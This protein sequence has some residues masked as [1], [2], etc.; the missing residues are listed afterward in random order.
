MIGNENCGAEILRLDIDSCRDA[1]FLEKPIKLK[2][3]RFEDFKAHL[4]E[5]TVLTVRKIRLLNVPVTKRMVSRRSQ[6]QHSVMVRERV[7]HF[8]GVGGGHSIEIHEATTNVTPQGTATEIHHDS[9]PHIST[10]CGESGTSC[11]QPM[12]LW[13]LWKASESRRLATCYSDTAAALR[14][15]GPCRYPIQYAGESLLL[16]ANVP[17]AALS[18]S[19]RYLYS[20]TFHA[21]GRARDP[22]TLELELSALAKRF[23]NNLIGM[24]SN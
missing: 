24:G 20:Q 11:E 12:K 17:H 23:T 21:E 2:E 13:L 10:A 15:L 5:E 3:D 8:Y 9:D 4:L 19:P 18:L 6:S 22:T 16:P 7:Q 1:W 14:Q